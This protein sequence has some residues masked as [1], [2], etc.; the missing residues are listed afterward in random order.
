MTEYNH[1]EAVKIHNLAVDKHE[2]L[3]TTA[4]LGCLGEIFFGSD[5]RDAKIG[6]W[7]RI[8]LD[9]IS[10]TESIT[11]TIRATPIIPIADGKYQQAY[12]KYKNN[13]NYGR[14]TLEDT[15]PILSKI[16]EKKE[17]KVVIEQLTNTFT[18][19]PSIT[20]EFIADT[21]NALVE[22]ELKK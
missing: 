1:K 2:I 22:S 17:Y 8:L 19:Q 5:P 11:G 13:P 9:T 4:S 12:K 20:L 7:E 16:A 21:I 6:L 10:T 15:L 14:W 3:R 18:E